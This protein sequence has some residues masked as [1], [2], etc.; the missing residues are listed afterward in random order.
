MKI[1]GLL[2]NSG[3][4][5]KI[6]QLVGISLFLMLFFSLVSIWITNGDLTNIGSLKLAQFLQ[7]LGLFV[8]PPFIL[9]YLWSENPLGYLRINRNPSADNIVLAIVIMLSAIPAINLLA[10]LNHVIP[11]PESLSWLET[12]LTDLEKRA[13]D[14]TLRMLNVDSLTGLLVNLGLIAVVPAI[15]EELFFRGIIQRVLQDKFKAHAAV[16]ITAIIFSAIHFQFFGFIPRM[17]MGALLGY[18]FLW[19]GNIWVPVAAHFTNNAAAVIY[20]F[21]RGKGGITIDLENTGKSETYFIGIISL[22]VVAVLVFYFRR[23][24]KSSSPE[25]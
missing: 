22:V 23:Q 10:E 16:W 17:L 19:T 15:G 2:I 7:S 21:F 18:L 5:S 14:L 8:L 3:T 20:Y 4:G 11:F 25:D 6:I 13:E 1:K 12:H 24:T 9:A